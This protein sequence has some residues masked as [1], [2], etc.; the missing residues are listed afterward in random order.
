MQPSRRVGRRRRRQL[1][2]R[3]QNALDVRKMNIKTR[4]RQ[5]NEADP[6]LQLIEAQL[7]KERTPKS[8]AKL[9]D[10]LFAAASGEVEIVREA[11]ETSS[12]LVVRPPQP[13]N[14]AAPFGLGRR[15]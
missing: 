7:L 5:M 12:E 3:A 13:G 14:A 4:L 2:L 9:A 15:G 11:L 1:Q 10:M 6:V 8:K